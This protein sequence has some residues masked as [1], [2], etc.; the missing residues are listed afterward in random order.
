MQ[1]FKGR[2]WGY[3]ARILKKLR[4]RIKIKE[5]LQMIL[6]EEQLEAKQK[7]YHLPGIYHSGRKISKRP[8]YYEWGIK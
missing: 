2:G 6:V 3:V 7:A 1:G 8:D 4:K 5:V